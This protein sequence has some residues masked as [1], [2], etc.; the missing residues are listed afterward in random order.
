MNIQNCI[1]AA[2]S[3]VSLVVNCYPTQAEG[4][5]ASW[6]SVESCKKE[7]TSGVMANGQR[8]DNNRLSCASWDYA[9][10]TML[11]VTNCDNNKWVIVEV[12]DRGPNKRLYKM[13]RVIDLSE[14]AFSKIASLKQGIIPIQIEKVALC[15]G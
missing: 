8:F 11:R 14:A 12:T 5:T 3:V 7:G 9:F 10:G 2:V 13:G 1:V 15:V 6:Y 4:L